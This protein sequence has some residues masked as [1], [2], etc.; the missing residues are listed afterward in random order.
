MDNNN[1]DLT[2]IDP[3]ALDAMRSMLSDP[4]GR[5]L[6][7]VDPRAV[8]AMRM[9][10]GVDDPAVVAKAQSDAQEEGAPESIA[11]QIAAPGAAM[12]GAVSNLSTSIG[13]PENPTGGL[14]GRLNAAVSAL[15]Q[16]ETQAKANLALPFAGEMADQAI[17][18]ATP[19]LKAGAKAVAKVLPKLKRFGQADAL[20]DQLPEVLGASDSPGSNMA[21]WTKDAGLDYSDESLRS[22]F[23]QHEYN[24][25]AAAETNINEAEQALSAAKQGKMVPVTDGTGPTIVDQKGNVIG[26]GMGPQEAMDALK[27]V[28]LKLRNP[29]NVIAAGGSP[30]EITSSLTTKTPQDLARLKGDLI[31]FIEGLRTENGEQAYPGLRDALYQ[32]K[33]AYTKQDV[34]S[35][36]PKNLKGDADVLKGMTA[37]KGI[38]ALIGGTVGYNTDGV[39]GGLE[40]VGIGAL[41]GNA[42]A[43]A[44]SSPYV[45][46]KALQAA[47]ATGRAITPGNA[48]AL[49]ALANLV[50]NKVGK[51]S[52]KETNGK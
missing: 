33:L 30:G 29:G 3:R 17:D 35:P 6:E 42:M 26:K 48:A 21:A 50:I 49:G 15:P 37:A 46:T 39:R 25:P 47:Q 5:G 16:T 43:D 32:D 41:G 22:R 14:L 38:G 18:A 24:T 2:G 7:G 20:V 45:F 23:P 11:L 8:Q 9:K 52:G 40:G 36:L 13:G 51:D 28:Q 19:G 1:S 27:S 31:D 44:L 12:S 34:L 10:L 4:A